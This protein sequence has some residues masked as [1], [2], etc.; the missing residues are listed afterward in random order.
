MLAEDEARRILV[1]PRG[2]FATAF[3]PSA[4]LR[5]VDC[6]MLLVRV[7]DRHDVAH[8]HQ[9]AV[10]RDQRRKGTCASTPPSSR[11]AV[12]GCRAI[13]AVIA[14]LARPDAYASNDWP[15]AYIRAITASASG[16]ESASAR[17]I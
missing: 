17:P 8:A 13:G 15:P 3:H 10:S 16:C 14:L 11:M 5:G 9:D 7:F 1:R 6:S 2:W 12:R 4:D